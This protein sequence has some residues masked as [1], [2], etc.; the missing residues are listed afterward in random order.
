MKVNSL[1]Q[2][3]KIKLDGLERVALRRGPL[4][5]D[6]N[7]FSNLTFTVYDVRHSSN[8]VHDEFIKKKR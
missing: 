6:D 4:Q 2:K 1:T 7:R 3:I 5:R 8:D